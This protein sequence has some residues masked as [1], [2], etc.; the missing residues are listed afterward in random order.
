MVSCGEFD[1]SGAMMSVDPSLLCSFQILKPAGLKKSQSANLKPLRPRSDP[2]D[3][4]DA[5]RHRFLATDQ[6]D[7]A[8]LTP[9]VSPLPFDPFAVA[10]AD[11]PTPSIL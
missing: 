11:D 3:V 1:N 5:V 9:A 10:P 7:W 4:T 6:L 8:H 2:N